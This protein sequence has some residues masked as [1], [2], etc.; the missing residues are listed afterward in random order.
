MEVTEKYELSHQQLNKQMCFTKYNASP[1]SHSF[2]VKLNE[3][4]VNTDAL[5]A[6][7]L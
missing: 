3:W 5:T 7:A 4:F 2:I 1:C 6:L